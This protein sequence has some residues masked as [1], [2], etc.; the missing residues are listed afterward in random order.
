MSQRIVTANRLKDGRVVYLTP[1]AG[2]S[3]RIA[4]SRHAEG[5]A[6]ALPEVDGSIVVDP[7]FVEV[8]LDGGV[9]RPVLHRERIRAAGPTEVA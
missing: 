6:V 5:A 2:W 9:P 3:Q 4:D 7:Y 8:T 1:D